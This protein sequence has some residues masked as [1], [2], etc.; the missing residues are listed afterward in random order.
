VC[1]RSYSRNRV[2]EP[3]CTP[4]F[5][6]SPDSIQLLLCSVGCTA[7]GVVPRWCQFHTRTEQRH[8]TTLTCSFVEQKKNQTPC[9]YS[10]SELYRPS[11]RR[12]STKLVPT[13][14]DRGV[15]HGQRDGSLR[16]YSR[17]SRPKPLLFLPSS[18]V[19]LTRLRGPRSRPTTSQKMW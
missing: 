6:T 14:A 18:S 15:P 17:I 4:H 9:P 8:G 5:G 19:V 7:Q 12:L 13:L 2:A 11:D 10:A 1:G 16:P 3:G